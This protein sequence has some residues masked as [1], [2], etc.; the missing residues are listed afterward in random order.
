VNKGTDEAGGT[1]GVE[2][3]SDE[4]GNRRGWREVPD[5]GEGTGGGALTG[6]REVEP[7]FVTYMSTI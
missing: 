7:R 5:E 2:R 1:G 6:N 4:A 3:V